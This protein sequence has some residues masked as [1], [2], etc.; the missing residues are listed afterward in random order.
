[1][2]TLVLTGEIIWRQASE[3]LI[4]SARYAEFSGAVTESAVFCDAKVRYCS[5]WRESLS[6]FDYFFVIRARGTNSYVSG[7]AVL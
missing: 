1:M 4:V 6:I 7:F 3:C 5:D 2:S